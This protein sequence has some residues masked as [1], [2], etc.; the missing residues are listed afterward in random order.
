M[1]IERIQIEEG[2]LDGLDL[3]F[4]SGLNVIFGPR[5]SGKTSLLEL[6]R[7]C[8][9]TQS[10]SN[11][12]TNPDVVKS[13]LGSGR[14]TV[15]L[16]DG[17]NEII[18]TRTLEAGSW[19]RTAAYSQP[20][21]FL[22]GEIEEVALGETGRL[23]LLDGLRKSKSDDGTSTSDTEVRNHTSQMNELKLELD[24]VDIELEKFKDVE[25]AL[26]NAEAEL[27][28]YSTVLK[29]ATNLQ[30]RLDE[31]SKEE[32]QLALKRDVF[33]R[34]NKKLDAWIKKANDLI[35]TPMGIEDWPDEIGNEKLVDI[36]TSLRKVS[37][38]IRGWTKDAEQ[39]STAIANVL[40]AIVEE[41][42]SLQSKSRELRKEIERV[43][44][45]AGVLAHRVGLEKNSVEKKKELGKRRLSLTQE[46]QK[47]Q[48]IRAKL[49]DETQTTDE[50]LFQQ[51]VDIAQQ[52]CTT[53]APLIRVSVTRAGI[54]DSYRNSLEKNLR[55]TGL[56]YNNLVNSIVEK[57]SPREFAEAIEAND[58]ETLSKLSEIPKG[59]I[60]KVSAQIGLETIEEL[61]LCRLDDKVDFSLLDGKSYKDTQYLS[62]GQRCTV[63]LPILLGTSDLPLIIDQ[64]EDNLDNAFI[65][66]TL[67]K[68][69]RKRKQHA[70]MILTTHNANIPVLG[71]AEEV[72]LLAS[73]GK[74]GYVK[75]SGDLDSIDSINAISSVMEGGKEAFERRSTFYKR[76]DE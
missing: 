26:K 61:L 5:G 33:E 56:H 72:V 18:V 23:K 32:G 3:Y 67:I 41:I 44:E 10:L 59:R 22:Q 35:N 34:T 20:L 12:R 75:F 53:Y 54:H 42:V 37:A 2:F 63:V 45:G 57:I 1:E 15:T 31:V 13:V 48:A 76:N 38:N 39:Q 9:G 29:G 21:F 47:L 19:T 24:S 50:D 40:G 16:K 28:K 11:R 55:G 14:V 74:R 6:L 8:L 64:P 27:A 43:Q 52:I 7:F 51:R 58:L 62:P 71:S 60:E 49:L 25:S 69:I 65:V 17:D 4:T 73:D 36:R 46:I 70:Q 68:A 30:Q 66:D